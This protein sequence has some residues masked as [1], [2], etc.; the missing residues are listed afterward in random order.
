LSF[1]VPVAI[2]LRKAVASTV[3]KPTKKEGQLLFEHGLD[4]RADVRPQSILD[5]VKPGFPGQ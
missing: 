1:A 4:G 5:R 3:T 2:P